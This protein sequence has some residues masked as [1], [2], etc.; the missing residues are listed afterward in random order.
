MANMGGKDT[1][2]LSRLAEGD[3]VVALLLLQR[4]RCDVA[5]HGTFG[6]LHVIARCNVIFKRDAGHCQRRGSG[7]RP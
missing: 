3:L 5:R 4:C 7:R 1:R 6:L 2:V